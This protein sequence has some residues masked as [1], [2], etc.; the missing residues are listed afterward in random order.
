VQA[1]NSSGANVQATV[2]NVGG[3]ASPDY[4]L[5]IQGSDYSPA[6]IQLSDGSKDLLSTLSPGSYVSYQVN[7]QPSTVTSTS[8]NLAISSGLTVNVLTTGTANVTVAENADG[9]STALSNFVASFNSATDE[10]TKS[11]GQNGGALAGQSIVSELSSSLHAL[12]N[13]AGSTNTVNSLA[14][15]GVTFD[16]NGHLQFDSTV[17]DQASSTSLSDV[18]NFLGSETGGGFLQAASSTLTGVTDPTSGLITDASN[19][20]GT[21]I[22]N[23]TTQISN[24]QDYISQMQTNLT[25]QM[26]AA[27]SAI[28]SLEQQVSQITNLFA[29]MTQASKNITG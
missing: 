4:R 20:L 6:T 29:A 15:L 12:T 13:Y 1:I 8:R 24:K 26:A 22:N 3:S 18:V 2:V 14:D 16:Q 5:S 9:V 19:S 28:S 25:A 21:T 11:R 10:L 27:D 17:F 7:G 23:L